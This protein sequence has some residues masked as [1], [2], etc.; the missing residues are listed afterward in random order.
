MEDTHG[1]YIQEDDI[2]GMYVNMGNE[3]THSNGHGEGKKEF[4]NLVDTIKSFQKEV[5][6]YKYDNERLMKSKE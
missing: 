3:G 2:I 4:M 1:D 6:C 5:Q